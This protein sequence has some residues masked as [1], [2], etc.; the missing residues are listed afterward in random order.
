MLLV[1]YKV[2][3]MTHSFMVPAGS[4]KKPHKMYDDVHDAQRV[5]LFCALQCD[6]PIGM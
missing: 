3:I 2:S 1:K 6:A 4:M 5:P